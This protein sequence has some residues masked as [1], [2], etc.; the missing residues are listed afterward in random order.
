MTD[1]AEARPPTDAELA[2]AADDIAQLKRDLAA[3]RDRPKPP[4]TSP[5]KFSGPIGLDEDGNL[6]PPLTE[7]ERAHLAEVRRRAVEDDAA[8]DA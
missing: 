7:Q 1:D 6:Q 4:V 3:A 5:G 8:P 2:D